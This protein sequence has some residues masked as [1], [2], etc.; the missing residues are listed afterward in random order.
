MQVAIREVGPRDGFQNEPEVIATDDKVRLI[1][2]LARSGLKRLEV[3]SFVRADVIPQLA[4]G[5]EVLERIDVPDDV[6]LS[7]LIPN[8]R[9]L[10][11]ALALRD[12]FHEVNVFLS[13]TESH[14]RANVNR[15]V[16]ESP[17]RAGAGARA[18]ASRRGCAARA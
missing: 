11:N 5:A 7:V 18:R 1:E 2:A 13:A 8:E 6:S 14:N 17:D 3:T 16:E 15:S 12:R 9:G 4:D 10:E